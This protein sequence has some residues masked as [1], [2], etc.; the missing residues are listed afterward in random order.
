MTMRDKIADALAKAHNVSKAGNGF[1]RDADAILAALPDMIPD[2]VWDVLATT[3]SGNIFG[4]GIYGID[5]GAT[6]GGYYVGLNGRDVLVD[7]KGNTLWFEAIA[8]AQAAANA[9]NRAAI[10]SAFNP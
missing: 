4:S 8:Q 2:L 6:K 3:E 10:M 5:K 1:N 9:H 7:D